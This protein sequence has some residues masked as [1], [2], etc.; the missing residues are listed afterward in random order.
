MRLF[1]EHGTQWSRISK[2]VAGRTAQQCRARFFQIRAVDGV[3]PEVESPAA[4]GAGRGGAGGRR[5]GGRS[6][7]SRRVPRLAVE[8]EDAEFDEEF[9]A[10]TR[11]GDRAT[12]WGP[13]TR[14]PGTPASPPHPQSLGNYLPRS[15]RRQI[16]RRPR[17]AP[18][19]PGSGASTPGPG[20]DG[21][22][23]RR[24]VG[25]AG[26]ALASPA[27]ASGR[28]ASRGRGPRTVGGGAELGSDAERGGAGHAGLRGLGA[29]VEEDPV[30]AA[31]ALLKDGVPVTYAGGRGG[32]APQ[33]ARL[34]PLQVRAATHLAR[35]AQPRRAGACPHARRPFLPQPLSP[36][37]L[38]RARPVPSK[39]ERA[40]AARAALSGAL[41]PPSVSPSL[42]GALARALTAGAGGASGRGRGPEV[43]EG[44]L[45]E[46]LLG[47]PTRAVGGFPPVSARGLGRRPIAI[48]ES[49][50]NA[51]ASRRGRGRVEPRAL[52]P[53]SLPSSPPQSTPSALGLW[54]AAQGDTPPSRIG[55][56]RL[57]PLPGVVAGEG[58]IAPH[59]RPA[60]YTPCSLRATPAP[61]PSPAAALPSHAT[62]GAAPASPRNHATPAAG[63][64]TRSRRDGRAPAEEASRPGTAPPSA[65]A[66]A[67]PPR[68]A[69]PALFSPWRLLPS[70]EFAS[71]AAAGAA[72]AL[73]LPPSAGGALRPAAT[74]ICA[75]LASPGAL[76]LDTPD[77]SVPQPGGRVGGG[78]RGAEE[79]DGE[80]EVKQEGREGGGGQDVHEG[81]GMEPAGAEGR[82]SEK[83][84]G[85]RR[86]GRGRKSGGGRRGAQRGRTGRW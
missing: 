64:R 69:G 63:V 9:E 46:A 49:S 86:V 35:L 83:R 67:L 14:W 82:A 28:R 41:G 2:L 81:R 24:R 10:R 18:E 40:A 29:A 42:A 54:G 33:W 45:I 31:A 44:R 57:S 62:D 6:G 21:G 65:L 85:R 3:V 32:A 72:D 34:P 75:A 15:S 13:G 56:G 8:D 39:A 22:A 74:P 48:R 76:G 23:K 30:L 68:H 77:L 27:A 20:A 16:V 58:R 53:R 80:V 70:E 79:G 52:M 38:D 11:T 61:S 37:R 84:G 66:L 78:W 50:W 71:P 60:C 59:P 55:A 51:Q 47:S 43:A 4:E 1:T 25:S 73:S 7:G 17:D 5:S 26:A 12:E 19:G 36:N